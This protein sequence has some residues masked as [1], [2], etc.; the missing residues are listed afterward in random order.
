MDPLLL[1]RQGLLFLHLVAFA[2]AFAEIVRADWRLLRAARIDFGALHATAGL[3]GLMLL[4]LWATGLGLIALDTGFDPAAI[5][6]KPKLVAKLIAVTVLTG[7]GVLLHHFAFPQLRSGARSPSRLTLIA[8][9][10]AIS[11]VTWTYAAFV[12][13]AR[14]IAGA[15]SLEAFLA[16]YGI[17]LV[18]GIAVAVIVVAPLLRTRLIAQAPRTLTPV[19]DLA[20]WTA[21]SDIDALD[22]DAPPQRKRA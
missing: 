21:D 4:L 18:T 5:A 9:L 15:M 12:G 6:G 8:A 7:N 3:V 11:T 13:S 2:I 20:Q 16:L 10:G 22:E 19:D 14:L 17:G 1:L